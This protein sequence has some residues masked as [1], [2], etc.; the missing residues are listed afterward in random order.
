MLEIFECFVLRKFPRTNWAPASSALSGADN[1]SRNGIPF[2]S[3]FAAP[4]QPREVIFIAARETFAASRGGDFPHHF[5]RVCLCSSL[6]LVTANWAPVT[7][8][9]IKGNCVPLVLQRAAPPQL[10]FSINVGAGYADTATRLRYQSQ[11]RET[12]FTLVFSQ[13]HVGNELLRGIVPGSL[14]GCKRW[15][16]VSIL[17]FAK[18]ISLNSAVA[19]S[20]VPQLS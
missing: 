4:T 10:C 15:R 7:A 16:R 14:C 1:T 20:P 17:I 2:M 19:T 11:L 5:N 13:L 8:S 3:T 9:N 6:P 18:V 12:L